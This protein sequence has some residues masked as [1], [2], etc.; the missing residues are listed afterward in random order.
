[1]IPIF[2]AEAEEAV[3]GAA[4]VY[5]DQCFDAY[6]RLKPEHF[7]EPVR[8][9]VW[10]RILEQHAKT[11]LPNLVSVAD[12][13]GE[14][15]GFAK[16]GGRAY[17]ADLL[18]EA[19]GWSVPSHVETIIDR[20]M[21]RDIQRLGSEVAYRAKDTAETTAEALLGD[22]ERQ[23]ADIAR[24]STTRSQAVPVGLTAVENLEAAWRGDFAG[25]PVG[26]GCLDD[27]TNGIRQDDVWVVGGRTSMGKSV[28]ALS[29]ARGIAQSGRGVLIFSLE[30]PTREVQARLVADIAY[31]QDAIYDG[32]FGG[33]MGYGDILKGRGPERLRDRARVAAKQLAS[34]PI[35]VTDAGGLTI[36][37]I[38]VQSL[39]QIRAWERLG[40]TAGAIII[41][42]LG[43]VRPVRKTDN[44]AADTAD[45]V[46]ELKGI[47]KQIKAPIIGLAQINRATE[48]RQDKRP[49]MSDMNWS[50]SIEQI[51]DLVCLLYR[52]SYYLERGTDDEFMRA[53]AVRNDID[54]II[55][56]NRSGPSLTLKA[57]VDVACNALR[58]K[59]G[60][61]R[62]YGS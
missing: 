1:M 61:R 34:L 22:L 46:N 38:R 43:L 50:G 7:Y 2:S 59:P 16:F 57:H 25:S 4:L 29:L 15:E 58:D 55:T 19:Q 52:E 9:R 51:A 30:M 45:T 62:A 32:P 60:E 56:K 6:E 33:N 31:D 23:A 14:D 21:R 26:L 3:I 24:E 42:H 10:A 11:G 53:A 47:A 54:L 27:V 18:S 41:D 40:V 8:A 5:H 37:D 12:G 49:T 20:A 35:M 28:F 13:V 39:R 36:D 17:L 44:K 48:S